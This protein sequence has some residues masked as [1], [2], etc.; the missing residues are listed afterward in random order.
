ML[1]DA[2]RPSAN[3]FFMLPSGIAQRAAKAAQLSDDRARADWESEGGAPGRKNKPPGK[4][5]S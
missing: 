4:V 1:A 3:R 2:G 5:P